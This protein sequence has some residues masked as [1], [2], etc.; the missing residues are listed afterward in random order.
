VGGRGLVDWT[1]PPICLMDDA[2]C[3]PTAPHRSPILPGIFYSLDFNSSFCP[4]LSMHLISSAIVQN[5][6]QITR[7]YGSCSADNL[8]WRMLP[9]VQASLP[10]SM[11]AM[12]TATRYL[13]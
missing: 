1:L 2:T 13:P 11:T 6:L 7:H 4:S 12:Q 10:A 8:T 5:L 3:R 9:P